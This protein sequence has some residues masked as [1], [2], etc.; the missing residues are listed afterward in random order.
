MTNG[1]DSAVPVGMWGQQTQQCLTKRELIAKD[2]LQ[3]ILS[4][5]G[6]PEWS[7]ENELKDKLKPAIKSSLVITDEFIKALN[8]TNI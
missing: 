7:D 2:L 8:E 1:N 6:L 3:S 5:H 4:K